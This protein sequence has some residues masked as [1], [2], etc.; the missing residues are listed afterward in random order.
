MSLHSVIYIIV[1]F[2]S[3]KNVWQVKEEYEGI[4]IQK[5]PHYTPDPTGDRPTDDD[6]TYQNQYQCHIY[7]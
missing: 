3:I 5:G 6:H 1:L 2:L 4:Q 7:Q